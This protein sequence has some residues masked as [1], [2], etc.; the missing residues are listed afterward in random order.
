M[1]LIDLP[2]HVE[3]IDNPRSSVH[4]VAH[5]DKGPLPVGADH[6]G[7]EVQGGLT[8]RYVTVATMRG[9]VELTGTE[10]AVLDSGEQR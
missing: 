10:L 7:T 5:S 8:V 6:V 4:V 9:S 2:F 1:A 3:S